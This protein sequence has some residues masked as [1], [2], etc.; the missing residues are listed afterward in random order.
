MIRKM[1]AMLLAAMMLLM[2][3]T[4]MAAA[5]DEMLN[6]AWDAG[7]TVTTTVT[8]EMAQ[9]PLDEETMTMINDM[10]SALGF[11]TV[12]NKEGQTQFAMTL[13]GQD[14]LNVAV[15]PAGDDVYLNTAFLAGSTM[16]FNKEE[17]EVVLMR[18]VDMAAQASGMDAAEVAAFKEGLATG[19]N[20]A[21]NPVMPTTMTVPEIDTEALTGLVTKIMES[22]E[23]GPVTEPLT[24]CDP[25]AAYAKIVITPEIVEETMT[26][27][28]DM[29]KS[30]PELLEA[31]QN[32]DLEWELDGRKV[33]M[34]EFFTEGPAVMAKAVKDEYGEV[35]MTIYTDEEGMPVAMTLIMTPVNGGAADMVTY[36]RQ[37]ADGAVSHIVKILE[38]DNGIAITFTDG[39]IENVSAYTVCLYEVAGEKENLVLLFNIKE[40]RAYGETTSEEVVSAVLSIATDD[41]EMPAINLTFDAEVVCEAGEK[42]ACTTKVDL[43]VQELGGKLLTVK[44]DTVA[45]DTVIPTIAT[46]AAVRPGAMTDAEFA[47]FANGC[48]NNMMTG[49]FTILQM[50]PASVLNLLM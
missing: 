46:P 16:A 29:I 4:G 32:T 21:E 38:G 8:F 33:T 27:V 15:E 31:F 37:T 6:A 10:V 42:V 45:D 34:D 30:M 50:L 28:F 20:A 1:F 36:G 14:A 25:A 3:M 47:E 22:V 43:G 9:L 48:T 7:K 44:V 13:Q 5:P 12:T 17:A 26:M 24:G 35:P 18:L 49:L 39:S 40:S 23:T 11:R 19:L 2:P 41:P